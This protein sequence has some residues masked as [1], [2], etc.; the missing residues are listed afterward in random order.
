MA[1]IRH[2]EYLSD[3][4]S[5]QFNSFLIGLIPA[6]LYR[7]FDFTPTN[8]LF[9]SLNH[10]TTGYQSPKLN[11]TLS[12]KTGVIRSK[13]GVLITEDT[14]ISIQVNANSTANPRID[15]VVC[16]HQY[17]L[18]AGGVDAEYFII[19]GTP[20]INPAPPIL[21]NPNFQ[22]IIGE[23]YLPANTSVLDA[24]G[25]I[26]TR[27]QLPEL[28]NNNLQEQQTILQ[29]NFNTLQENFITLQG[30][31]DTLNQEMIDWRDYY[32]PVMN[33]DG[34][35]IEWKWFGEADDPLVWRDL[36]QG[37]VVDCSGPGT[38]E[39]RVLEAQYLPNAAGDHNVLEFNT[40]TN[41][42]VGSV[43]WINNREW[44]APQTK[45]YRF[46]LDTVELEYTTSP[47]FATINADKEF[48]LMLNNIVGGASGDEYWYGGT[49]G[50]T[51]K[52]YVRIDVIKNDN[53]VI[54][55]QFLVFNFVDGATVGTKNL[56]PVIDFIT[57][58]NAS[59]KIYF[60][61]S[62][63]PPNVI[64]EDPYIMDSSNPERTKKYYNTNWVV[65]NHINITASHFTVFGI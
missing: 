46:L 35:Y 60:I 1:Q 51:S 56:L 49:G 8:N 3:D 47:N 61:I 32:R 2:T 18:I 29:Q 10:N 21:T 11:G 24:T 34:V 33:F 57:S 55:R 58:L 54:H 14:P 59:D 15:L 62:T 5:F 36:A 39:V 28:G 41:V 43:Y 12:S 45:N 40:Q 26:Y 23:L 7:G 13:Q 16:E 20:S 64:G 63:T 44:I 4:D 6:G 50:M 65:R 31:F 53:T 42:P 37:I 17:Q 30:H 9:L 38:M 27:P 52:G 25:V 19:Q 22:V 48:P